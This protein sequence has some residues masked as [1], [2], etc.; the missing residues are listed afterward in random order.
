MTDTELVTIS[1]ARLQELEA[2]EI[3]L[4][5]LLAKTQEAAKAEAH[6]ERLNK[7]NEKNKSNPEANT[8]RVMKYYETH[9]EEINARR[10]EAYKVKKAAGQPA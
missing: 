4:P 6:K 3:A 7:L 5:V 9:K 2:L 10:R 1:A 8:K